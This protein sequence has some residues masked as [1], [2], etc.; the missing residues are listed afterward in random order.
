VLA[1]LNRQQDPQAAAFLPIWR[2]MAES[3]IFAVLRAGWMVRRGGAIF[4]NPVENLPP[5]IVQPRGVTLLRLDVPADDVSQLV[6]GQGNPIIWEG[7]PEVIPGSTITPDPYVTRRSTRSGR[8][9][10]T[11][12]P[13]PAPPRRRV[14]WSRA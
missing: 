10:S 11:A 6:D 5:S 13:T 12:G 3:D 9:S 2:A 14:S 7:D 4:T 1:A 8:T